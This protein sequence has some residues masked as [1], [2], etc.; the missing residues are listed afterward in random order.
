VGESTEAPEEVARRA[1]EINEAAKRIAALFEPEVHIGNVDGGLKTTANERIWQEPEKFAESAAQLEQ[2]SLQLA[3]AA[4]AGDNA[5]I[6]A[7]IG[8]L[9][10]SCGGCHQLYRVKKN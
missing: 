2:A 5:K 1:R 4:E 8:D 9:G 3:M 7:A 10:K 6:R